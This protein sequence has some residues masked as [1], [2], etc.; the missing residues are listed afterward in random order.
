MQDP[1]QQRPA[2]KAVSIIPKD[3]VASKCYG[4][5]PSRLQRVDTIGSNLSGSAGQ[6]DEMQDQR[7]GTHSELRK[8]QV[9]EIEAVRD[10]GA[11]IDSRFV[12]S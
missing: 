3:E 10:A 9:M 5:K 12:Q 11:R 1:S 2:I 4:G 7:F 6:V 8:C